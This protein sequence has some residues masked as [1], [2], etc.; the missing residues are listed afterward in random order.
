MKSTLVQRYL[1]TLCVIIFSSC[2]PLLGPLNSARLGMPIEALIAMS[3]QTAT[4]E[5]MND[6]ITVYRYEWRSSESS[7]NDNTT[8]YYFRDGKLV[9]F[10]RG[11]RTTPPPRLNLNYNL[12]R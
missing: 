1:M 8:F 5:S 4:L 7:F 10:D 6:S 12:N 9:K 3:Q 11:V 2:A